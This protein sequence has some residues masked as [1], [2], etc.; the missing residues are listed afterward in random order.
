MDSTRKEPVMDAPTTRIFT[1]ARTVALVL[2]AL[3]VGGLAYLRFGLDSDP[4]SVKA[5]RPAT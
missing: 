2:I 1:P 5:R 4:V 3:L